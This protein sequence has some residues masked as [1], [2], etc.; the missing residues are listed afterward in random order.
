MDSPWP[1]ADAAADARRDVHERPP[2]TTTGGAAAQHVPPGREP[3]TAAEPDA[4]RW[5]ILAVLLVAIFMSLVGVSIVNVG[6]PSIQEGLGASR[7][8]IQWV[9]SGYALTFGVVLV[10]AGRA[11]DIFGRGFLFVL[12]VAVFTLASLAAGFASDPAVLT[13]ARFV[14]GLGSGLLN[15]QG[16]GMIQQYF[17]GAERGQAF[18]LFGSVVG[19]SVGVGPLLGGLLIHLGGAAEGWRWM[20]FVNVPLGVLALALAFAWFP[21]PLLRRGHGRTAAKVLSELDPVGALLLGTAVLALLLPFIEA[22]AATSAWWWALLPAGAALLSAWLL[23]ERR[24]RAA[25]RSPMVDLAI[26]RVRSFSYGS[27]LIGLYFLGVT[28]VWVLLA[29]YMQQGLGHTALESGLIGLPNALA[30][31]LAANW[32]GRHVLRLGRAVVVG[33]MLSVLLGLALSVLVIQLEGRGIG[34]EWW[35]LATLVLV[36]LGQGAVVSPNQTL[37]LAEV[38]L[39]YAGS[40]GGIMQTGQRIGTSIG[41]AV[42]T[43]VSFTVLPTAGWAQAITAGFAMIAAV[44]LCA[45]AVGVADL[46][47]RRRAGGR[48]A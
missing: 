37:S 8:Q 26:F 7:T 39:E 23:W 27:A 36:G 48:P 45:L 11:G 29:L 34:S 12:G 16:V 42:V 18:G 21:R 9:L 43:A 2:A 5:R 41:I 31:A 40:S 22:R 46:R 28:S 24:Y 15:P 1:G 3:R 6:L 4:D 20:F 44:I 13:A 32:A 25:G 47:H 30:S 19:I 35:L 33:G 14:Q 17:R 38:P 10:A